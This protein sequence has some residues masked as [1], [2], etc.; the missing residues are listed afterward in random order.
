MQAMCRGARTLL[1]PLLGGFLELLPRFSTEITR[2]G[3]CLV[4]YSR[5]QGGSVVILHGCCQY[6]HPRVFPSLGSKIKYEGGSWNLV[7]LLINEFTLCKNAGKSTVCL[8]FCTCHNRTQEDD[9]AQS[10]PDLSSPFRSYNIHSMIK[11]NFI[12]FSPS[13]LFSLYIFASSPLLQNNALQNR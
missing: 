10:N 1:R 13:L 11:Y 6:G 5:L 3:P 2:P 7:C 9:P 12:F 4:T 8:L